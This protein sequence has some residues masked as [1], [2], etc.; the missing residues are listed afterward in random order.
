MVCQSF[1]LTVVSYLTFLSRDN[2]SHLVLGVSGAKYKGFP[3][4]EKANQAYHRAK[5]NGEVRIVRNPGDDA[6]YGPLF[7]AIQ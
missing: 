2:V 7:Y 1:F 6:K 5:C 4:L 3:T